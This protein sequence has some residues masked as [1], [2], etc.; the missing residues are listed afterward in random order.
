MQVAV[1]LGCSSKPSQS[2]ARS[3]LEAA[4]QRFAAVCALLHGRVASGAGPTLRAA[5]GRGRPRPAAGLPGTSGQP[6]QPGMSPALLPGNA[7]M[8]ASA[9]GPARAPYSADQPKILFSRAQ[10]MTHLSQGIRQADAE[11]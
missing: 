3:V 6:G 11:E 8:R 7:V 9:P 5:T 10:G 1:V 2:A 4:K